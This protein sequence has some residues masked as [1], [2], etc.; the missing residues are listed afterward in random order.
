MRPN[1]LRRSQGDGRETDSKRQWS[2]YQ[3]VELLWFIPGREKENPVPTSKQ[4]NSR[5]AT[6]ARRE[7]S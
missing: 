7:S 4:L 5:Q 3:I 1:L 2:G 6:V